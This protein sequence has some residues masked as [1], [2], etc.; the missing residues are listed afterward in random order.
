MK[1]LADLLLLGDPRLYE[2]CEPVLQTDLPL[3]PGWVAD[4]E[5]VMQGIRAKYN[6]GRAIAAPQLGIMK[7]LIYM[8]IDQPTVFIN[9]EF[10][11]L[12]DEKF[13]LW[14]DCMSFPN[15]LV[16][17][18]RHQKLTIKYLDEDWQ[19]QEWHMEDDLA[20][21]LQH[22]YDHLEGILCISRAVDP[23]AFKWRL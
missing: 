18:A 4:M 10:I 2:K 20:E 19:P 11:E 3:V 9:P 6:F 12:S 7:R 16:K 15:L 5:N 13:E 22:E 1:T 23:K 21:L 14:D 17:V 8:N